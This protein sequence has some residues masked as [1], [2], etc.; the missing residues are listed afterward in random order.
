MRKKAPES[1]SLS[2]IALDFLLQSTLSDVLH[3]CA[4]NNYRL[5]LEEDYDG[6]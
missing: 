2:E 6:E 3:Y 1:I 4:M 5:V